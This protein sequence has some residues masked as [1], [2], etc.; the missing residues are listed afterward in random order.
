MNHTKYKNLEDENHNMSEIDELRHEI[1]ELKKALQNEIENRRKLA[2]AFVTLGNQLEQ[3]MKGQMTLEDLQN[4]LQ[5]VQEVVSI[6]ESTGVIRQG[7]G[8]GGLLASAL[9]QMLRQQQMTQTPTIEKVDTSSKK[10]K[11]LLEEP[12]EEED[13]ENEG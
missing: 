9:A 7:E 1:Q 3:H 12:D 5:K 10:L 6:L 2:K 8:G 4:C 11:K 13:D